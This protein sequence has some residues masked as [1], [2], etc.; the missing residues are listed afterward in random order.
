MQVLQ[1]RYIANV[2]ELV[3]RNLRFFLLF[4]AAALLL[5]LLF[6]FRFPGVVTD[7]FVYGDIAKNWLQHGIYG[8]SGPDE[9]SPTY[10]RL[11]GYPAFLAFIFAIFGMEHY[12]AVLFV[13]M[14]VDLGTCFLCAD[15]ALRLLAPRFAKIAFVL[16]CL[17]PFLADYS[18]AALTETLEIFFTAL[19][20]DLA[21]RALQQ[22]S[23]RDWTG[24]G[25]ACAAA[26]LL[27]PDGALLLMTIGLYLLARVLL[28]DSPGVG[29]TGI[30]TSHGHAMRRNV[31]AAT[32]VTV[33]ALA[34]LVPWA[35]RNWHAFH[36]LQPLAPRYANEEDEFVPMGFNRWV[37]TW[38][39]DYASTEEI[40]W[41][42]PGSEIDT[43][44]L[45]SR[46]F[47]S[48]QQQSETTALI[49]DYNQ[50]LHI[51][52]DLDKRFSV[53]A[54]GR[55]H[56]HPL[57]YYFGLPLLRILD[58]WLRPR[59]EMLPCDTRW[60]EFNDDAQWSLLAV[61]FGVINLGYFACALV[62][63]MYA[64]RL[65]LIGLLALFVVL[66]SG[67]LATLENPE[68]RYTLEIYPIVIVLAACALGK[69]RAG[70]KD[71]AGVI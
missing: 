28:P 61:A 62:G 71:R 66:R 6:I 54:T 45:P 59:T 48:L 24:C 18:A 41:A 14:F 16:A 25:M 12:R 29:R 50:E 22:N 9:I 34:P 10:I 65:P 30:S 15:I 39:A 70:P 40:Y 67:F 49:S 27:R 1:T 26:I 53:L 43:A 32:L 60:W 58:M 56:S 46:A 37:K 51:S 8:L 7:S 52:P 42:V 36:R 2:P 44:K 38:I 33:I 57:R 17:C 3:R 35:I 69:M 23:I 20:F 4:T 11:P 19:A 47:D 63:W 31:R 64:R 21:I 5:R 55:I 13:Q 68:P